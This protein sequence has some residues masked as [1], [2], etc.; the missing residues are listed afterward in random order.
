VGQPSRLLPDDLPELMSGVDVVVVRIL[1]GF[2][3][4]EDGIDAVSAA[5]FPRS[6]SAAHRPPTPT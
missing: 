6:W 2:R 1:G 4:W 5:V 3:A